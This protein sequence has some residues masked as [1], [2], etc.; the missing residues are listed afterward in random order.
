MEGEAVAVDGQ[1]RAAGEGLVVRVVSGW[2]V[3]GRGHVVILGRR[4]RMSMLGG[5]Q[6]AVL[7]QQGGQ[8]VDAHN[9]IITKERYRS[10]SLS[11]PP[12]DLPLLEPLSLAALCS[13]LGRV[14][15]EKMR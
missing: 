7:P 6:E 11:M 4:V 15:T 3:Q 2:D 12:A 1:C 5:R 14:R 10:A 13:L 9:T 8:A